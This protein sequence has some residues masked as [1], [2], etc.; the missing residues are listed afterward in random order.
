MGVWMGGMQ[1]R[2]RTPLC[3]PLLVQAP[4]NA[5]HTALPSPLV[6]ACRLATR[7][8][9]R[10]EPAQRCAPTLDEAACGCQG[11]TDMLALPTECGLRERAVGH[12]TA[13]AQTF[14]LQCQLLVYRRCTC[15]SGVTCESYRHPLQ[16]CCLIL[17]SQ[18]FDMPYHSNVNL[19]RR[20][21]IAQARMKRAATAA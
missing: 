17:K 15:G 9:A 5:L 3:C 13:R 19:I 16:S 6:Q 12:V 10:S 1:C 11:Q 7:R 8:C 4:P 18:L 14:P 21:A 20:A 2:Q